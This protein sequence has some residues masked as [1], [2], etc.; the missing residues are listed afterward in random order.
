MKATP[1]ELLPRLVFYS[2]E[3]GEF[4]ATVPGMPLVSALGETEAEALEELKS[5]MIVCAE[6]AEE[7]GLVFPPL[8]SGSLSRA[9]AM[10]NLSELARRIGTTQSTL[11]SKLKRGTDLKPGEAQAI[12]KALRESGVALIG[13]C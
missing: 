2:E 10:L 4:V 13:H 6:V 7:Q 11:A 3:D 5:V 12:N 8:E 1:L 9:S